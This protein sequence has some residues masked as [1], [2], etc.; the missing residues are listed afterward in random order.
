MSSEPLNIAAFLDKVR[1]LYPYGI[2]TD[3]I[4]ARIARPAE[5]P[6]AACLFVVVLDA[7]RLNDVQA[8]LINAI[9]T[10][11]LKVERDRCATIVLPLSASAESIRM[12]VDSGR[13]RLSI[14]LGSQAAHGTV[15]TSNTGVVLYSHSLPTIAENIAAKREFWALLQANLT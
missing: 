7:E 4:V 8:E 3:E 9:C 13:A 11:G 14:V 2:P 5:E 6:M 10:K 15:V 12:A 1:A